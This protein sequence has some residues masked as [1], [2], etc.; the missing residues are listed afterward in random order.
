MLRR[1]P[2]QP[3]LRA[4]VS[5]RRTVLTRSQQR[6]T[7]AACFLSWTLDAFDFFIMVFIL[8]EIAGNSALG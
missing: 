8:A 7:V 4:K 3:E 6:H 5:E 1:R 2:G